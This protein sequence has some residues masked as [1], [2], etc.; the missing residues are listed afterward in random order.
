MTV[1]WNSI[2]PDPPANTAKVDVDV[3][4][5]AAGI[6]GKGANRTVH[7][8]L[9]L[10][11]VMRNGGAIPLADWPTH[12]N[13]VTRA[14][15]PV[16]PADPAQRAKWD[17]TP[18][19]KLHISPAQEH[20]DKRP[21]PRNSTSVDLKLSGKSLDGLSTPLTAAWR[22]LMAPKIVG[23]G[24]SNSEHDLSA[25]Q[26]LSDIIKAYSELPSGPSDEPSLEDGHI[27]GVPRGDIALFLSIWRSRIILDGLSNRLG[28][29][30]DPG[31]DVS[32]VDKTW[33]PRPSAI[34]FLRDPMSRDEE[35]QRLL[36]Q[37]KT[38]SEVQYKS[39]RTYQSAADL[40]AAISA[41]FSIDLDH[42]QCAA[43][44]G[45]LGL[46]AS[47]GEKPGA[48]NAKRPGVADADALEQ[49]LMR[50]WLAHR[51][52]QAPNSHSTSPPVPERLL[53]VAADTAATKPEPKVD[54]QIPETEDQYVTKS[55][56]F[57][58]QT[59]PALA[60]I[61]GFAVDVYADLGTVEKALGRI[62][63]VPF[64]EA[65]AVDVDETD[66]DNVP[67]SSSQS[68]YL[69]L[70]CTLGPPSDAKIP[71]TWTTAKLRLPSTDGV[72]KG[73]IGHFFPCTREEI[74]LAAFVRVKPKDP[75]LK[76]RQFLDISGQRAMLP[77]VMDGAIKQFDGVMDLG[78]GRR[79]VDFSNRRPRFDI[80]TLESIGALESQ[81]NMV[82]GVHDRKYPT[83]S[84]QRPTLMTEGL[85]LVDRWRTGEY[86]AQMADAVRHANTLASHDAVV[87]DANDLAIGVRVDVGVRHTAHPKSP[88]AD[89]K[90]VR[91]EWRALGVRTVKYAFAGQHTAEPA[92]QLAP[93]LFE[94]ALA[95][96]G[97]AAGSEERLHLDEA[98]SVPTASGSSD[99][100]K[101][102]PEE[103]LASW[104][105]EP[106]GLQCRKETLYL[107]PRKGL[108][109]SMIYGFPADTARK[110]PRLMF[111]RRYRLGLRLVYLG[112]VALPLA[113]AKALY[114]EAAGGTLALPGAPRVASAAPQGWNAANADAPRIKGRRFLRHERIKAP[115]ILLTEKQVLETSRQEKDAPND[116]N[117]LKGLEEALKAAGKALLDA[118]GGAVTAAR[119]KLREAQS[120]VDTGKAQR[121][122]RG[123]AVEGAASVTLRKARHKSGADT[124][125]DVPSA[126]RIVVPPNESQDFVLRHGV[127]DASAP[128][129]RSAAAVPDDRKRVRLL[130]G[131]P[132]VRYDADRGGFPVRM[133]K[134]SETPI[135]GHHPNVPAL[136]PSVVCKAPVDSSSMDQP[137]SGGDAVF[138]VR[139]TSSEEHAERV[140]PYFPDPAAQSIVLALR[141]VRADHTEGADPKE[142]DYLDKKALVVPLTAKIGK[143]T[144]PHN[145]VS[146][147]LAIEALSEPVG[148]QPPRV[149]TLDNVLE[150]IDTADTGVITAEGNFITSN[151]NE[152]DGKGTPARRVKIRL[153]P[154]ESFWLDMWCLPSEEAL[155]LWFDAVESAAMLSVARG[156][157]LDP[158]AGIEDK[159]A[160]GFTELTKRK[161]SLANFKRE[162]LIG[163]ECGAAGAELPCPEMQKAI[164]TTIHNRLGQY[165]LP[166][167]ASVRTMRLTY[168]VSQPRAPSF[169]KHGE[170]RAPEQP[171]SVPQPAS[172]FDRTG[173]A[174]L[175]K[176]DYTTGDKDGSLDHQRAAFVARSDKQALTWRREDHDTGA[177]DLL[178]GGQVNLDLQTASGVTLLADMVSP[179]SSRLDDPA[180]GRPQQLLGTPLRKKKNNN[181]KREEW[182]NPAEIYGFN[183]DEDGV[184]TFPLQREVL[185]RLENLP[186]PLKEGI[187]SVDLLLTNDKERKR[188]MW[189]ETQ[190]KRLYVPS[191][192]KARR[193][194]VTLEA[195][196]RYRDSFVELDGKS[197]AIA[198]EKGWLSTS[199]SISAAVPESAARP[200][201][202]QQP[203]D[204]QVELW[205][206]ST[207]RPRPIDP[208]SIIPAFIWRET[209]TRLADT[210]M[211][212]GHQR[213][214]VRLRFRRPWFS[215]GEGER[216]GIVLWPSAIF[217]RRKYSLLNG[218][219]EGA[220]T[221]APSAADYIT[222]WA[223]DPIGQ[224]NVD[225]A[226][227]MAPEVFADFGGG[228]KDV[229]YVP[230]VD[231]PLPRSGD[232]KDPAQ[233]FGAALLA[234]T[235]RFDVQDESWYADVELASGDIANCFVQFG[236]VRFQPASK[237]DV[238]VSEPT[239][240]MVQ[241]M[242]DREITVRRE[243]KNRDAEV[244]HSIHVEMAGQSHLRVAKEAVKAL[245][246]PQY[247]IRHRPV[248][249]PKLVVA[250]V[251]SQ[252]GHSEVRL[253]RCT[254][255]QGGQLNVSP[256]RDHRGLSWKH[257]FV[258]DPAEILTPEQ[259]QRAGIV[260]RTFRVVLDEVN[261]MFSTDTTKAEL[262][263]S[264]L[265]FAACVDVP[266]YLET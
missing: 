217:D 55:R 173:I 140:V 255:G 32:S 261:L 249:R 77:A 213:M 231:V 127:T 143:R 151:L 147:F 211:A 108:G 23:E 244:I 198:P 247:D 64:L 87:L 56:I 142:D 41:L 74:D 195:Q 57:A 196:A 181:A 61:F 76:E 120:A 165:P 52:A 90:S 88:A 44:A 219:F 60:R 125:R 38:Q 75:L 7:M 257:S 190:L 187:T 253:A 83:H 242:P 240:V 135:G 156:R 160:A 174:M 80:V 222:R 24:Q 262:V 159:C 126:V 95:Q 54:W 154:G 228:R 184:V 110:L 220:G 6:R 215:S 245:N 180:R 263:P 113:R 67:D 122:F 237:C 129:C 163:F 169:V 182:D 115:E 170:R 209:R 39:R 152:W 131:L 33:S 238:A 13:D 178:I 229:M 89:K 28:K 66:L 234:Y 241:I 26:H 112:G 106:M 177:T 175:R 179:R 105:G 91:H 145:V 16:P 49:I 99:G 29:L 27:M 146:L 176:S 218:F 130:D 62:G 212:T 137:G 243:R 155:Q 102:H 225:M 118:R 224:G 168:A 161:V 251:M 128:L 185:L 203:K 149:P 73:A 65:D 50:Y 266:E 53:D 216:L 43:P 116:E 92:L 197:D 123:Y 252:G 150:H 2:D 205:I 1:L 101:T 164:A 158:K 9:V 114:E 84:L 35:Q 254:P 59:N 204:G 36:A 136:G 20:G 192:T 264:G 139:P 30:S 133:P 94:R 166:E 79:A 260:R 103:I 167:L 34:D 134:Q 51:D 226:P 97:Y 200:T 31:C 5:V 207:T 10:S 85:V 48:A 18:R 109:V 100:R 138:V 193:V 117:R 93:D 248:M 246:E 227:Y 86:V 42:C 210:S 232:G 111:G 239:S 11:P 107:D 221:V 141:R 98:M 172:D 199:T 21:W 40:E 68:H 22:H 208:K 258:I 45:L 223:A 14:L 157:T 58:L 47:A 37:A 162:E 201:S 235:P 189:P 256:T 4:V 194:I 186:P 119:I 144:Y 259:L 214:I 70:S 17:R 148:K 230:H 69:F 12:I 72:N 19:L 82:R 236:L 121:P 202:A 104:N 8:T 63:S 81:I 191:D 188:Q 124:R 183:V 3:K 233:K 25:W 153:A 15:D 265:R 78:A 171:C 71:R 250:D 206:P 46:L 132:N 96:L